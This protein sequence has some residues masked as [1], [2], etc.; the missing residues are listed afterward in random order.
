MLSK[1]LGIATVLIGLLWLAKPQI[2]QNRLKR[3]M[4]R[5]LR[6]AVFGFIVA[7]GFLIVGSAFRAPGLLP[8]I[9]GIIGLVIAI[10]GILVITSKASEK[11]LEWLGERPLSFFRI[12]ATVV[13]ATGVMLFLTG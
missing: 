6:F 4:G 3:K 10:K 8:K 11:M 5:K 9:V 2:L 12:W 13:V 7:F 1:V